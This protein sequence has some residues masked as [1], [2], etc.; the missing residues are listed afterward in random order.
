MRNQTG[1]PNWIMRGL[2]VLLCL[3][4]AGP[5]TVLVAQA[6]VRLVQLFL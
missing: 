3:L 4:L 1:G 2:A 6:L 5:L